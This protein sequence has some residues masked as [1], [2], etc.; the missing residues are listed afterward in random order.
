MS[1]LAFEPIC[2]VCFREIPIETGG[3][4]MSCGDFL[5]PACVSITKQ[6]QQCP[7]CLKPN[8][9]RI[10]LQ[11]SEL[12][13]QVIQNMSD[14]TQNL[15]TLH[16]VLAFQIKHYKQMSKRAYQ[17]SIQIQQTQRYIFVYIFSLK[18]VH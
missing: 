9:R 7:G 6:Q 5:C 12:P 15:E 4:V 13:E 10:N 2:C 3:M 18:V 1:V 17:T 11:S 16:R 8:V 14:I